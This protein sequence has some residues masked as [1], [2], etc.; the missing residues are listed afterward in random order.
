MLYAKHAVELIGLKVELPMVLEMDN[1]GAVDHSNSWSVG[2]HMRH[3]G[4]KQVFLR[5]LK[6]DGILLVK[7]ISTDENE[8]DLFTKNLDGPLFAKFAKAF[9]G[10]DEYGK[11]SDGA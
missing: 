6:E 10:D 1:K 9:V 5:E 2:G 7:W 4:T 11:K 8:A 3:V